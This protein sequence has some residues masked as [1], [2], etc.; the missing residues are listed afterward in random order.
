[1]Q[2]TLAVKVLHSKLEKETSANLRL[3]R[4]AMLTGSLQHPGIPPVFEYGSLVGG[5]KYFAMKLVEGETLDKVF[6]DQSQSELLS[7]F[8]QV[9]EAVGFAHSK[10][11]IHRDLKPQNVMVGAFGEVQIMDWGLAITT[12]T[13]FHKI[14]SAPSRD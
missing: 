5:S 12:E 11:V 8:R 9:A 14:H 7:I 3:E 4:E 6:S 10:N 13:S 2:R 1:M